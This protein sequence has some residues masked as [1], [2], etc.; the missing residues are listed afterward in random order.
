MN[1]EAMRESALY[2][3]MNKWIRTAPRHKD[4]ENIVTIKIMELQLIRN[5]GR[6]LQEQTIFDLSR[7]IMDILYELVLK[8]TI[9]LFLIKYS[10]PIGIYEY[11]HIL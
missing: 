2:S 5:K 4:A 9:L 7:F 10:F 8:F 1:R 6:L 11:K 3:K